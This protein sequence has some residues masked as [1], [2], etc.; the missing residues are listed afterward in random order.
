MT[1]TPE[2]LK[3]GARPYSPAATSWF[4]FLLQP[5][6]LV[7]H[8]H[9]PNAVP[10][11]HQLIVQFLQ[12]ANILEFSN[13]HQTAESK[14]TAN[15]SSAKEATPT[16]QKE[17]SSNSNNGGTSGSSSGAGKWCVFLCILLW[18]CVVRAKANID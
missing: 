2:F 13:Q 11:A 12:Q 15:D 8:L 18:G 10:G 1:S 5:D 7:K 3:P 17:D 16:V 4:E 9:N 14:S 6:L